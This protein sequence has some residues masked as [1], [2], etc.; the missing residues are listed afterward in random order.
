MAMD[1]NKPLLGMSDKLVVTETALTSKF[2][3]KVPSLPANMC[4]VLYEIAIAADSTFIA[5]GKLQVYINGEPLKKTAGA[6]DSSIGILAG[7]QFDF[8]P[9]GAKL[10]QDDE[11]EVSAFVS[12]GTGTLQVMLV[13]LYVQDTQ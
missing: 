3:F 4:G 1:Y 11:V 5:N 10:K 7:L 6:S 13:G 12:S 8:R 9:K 2:K